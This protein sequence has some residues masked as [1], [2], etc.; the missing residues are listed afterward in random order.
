VELHLD[1]HGELRLRGFLGIPLLGQTQTWTRYAGPL[2]EDCR[3][4]SQATVVGQTQ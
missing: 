2:P 3:L 4:Y 1:P